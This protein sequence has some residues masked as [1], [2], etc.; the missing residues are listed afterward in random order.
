MILAETLWT[1]TLEDFCRFAALTGDDNPIHLDPAYAAAHPFGRPVSHGMLIHARL[2]AL[3]QAAGIVP[4]GRVQLRFANPAYAGAPLTLR[5]L[6]DGDGLLGLALREDLTPVCEAVWSA[7]GLQP[8]D[9]A[10]LSRSF[11]AADL[12]D[13]AA[14]TG[15][16]LGEN[17][18][19]P[20]IA[21][22]FSCLLGTQL[23]GPGTGWLKQEMHHHAKAGLDEPLTAE[24]EITRLRPEKRL[25]DL[26]CR[27][28][29]AGGRAICSGRALM[30]LAPGVRPG[31]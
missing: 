23:P 11:S 20:L 29:G 30:L 8:G 31:I 2:C 10:S 18:P 4:T 16:S 17:V 24:V 13:F 14:L 6:R 7:P 22:L 27:C 15:A 26:A 21:G 19:E 12:A 28:H 3:A 25:V 9:R 5:L 1:P